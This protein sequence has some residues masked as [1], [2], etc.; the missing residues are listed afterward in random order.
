MLFSIGDEL[1][2]K[3]ITATDKRHPEVRDYHGKHLTLTNRS[4]TEIALAKLVDGAMDYELS[5]YGQR[6]L[7]CHTSCTQLN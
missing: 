3:C 5:R 6:H 1:Q 7:Y 4:P 2:A